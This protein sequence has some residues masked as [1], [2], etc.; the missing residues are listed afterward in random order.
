MPMW[1]FVIMIIRE[2]MVSGIR[3]LVASKGVVIPA[4][5]L[6]KFKTFS[7]MVAICI[8]FFSQAHIA[9]AYAGQAV[10]Y[11]ACLFTVISG[12]EYFWQSR[13]VIFESI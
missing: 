12:V 7:T 11:V 13:K 1:A 9:I 10:M 6:G 4:G 5:K 2:F 8:L 3:M